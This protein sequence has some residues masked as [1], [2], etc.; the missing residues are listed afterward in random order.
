MKIITIK[1]VA[2]E[3]GVSIT[4]VSHSLSGGGVISKETR[5]HV[6]K[7]A[8]EMQYVPNLNGKNLKAKS[9]KT[10]G[11]FVNS[12][13][14][15]YYGELADVMF[16]E[17][18]K[19]GYNLNIFLTD[20]NIKIMTDIIGG[21]V[22]GAVILNEWVNEE[23]VQILRSA[24][25]PTVFIDREIKDRYISSIVFDSY[26]EGKMAAEYLLSLGHKKIAYIK[27]LPN[28]YDNIERWNGF[29]TA[30]E[31]AGVE[32]SEEYIWDGL[33][34]RNKAYESVS[35]FLDKNEHVVP[36]AIFAANDLSAFGCIEALQ[37]R[38]YKVPEDV[39]V[40]GCDDVELCNYF[41]PK[42]TTI[43]TSFRKQGILSIQ[44]ILDLLQK[45]ESVGNIEK[46]SGKIIARDSC[47][48]NEETYAKHP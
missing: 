12:L 21:R 20:Q 45:K 19:S 16:D 36:E 31:S 35:E 14:G 48:S 5:E 1:D 26:G 38:G 22:D 11:L 10:I 47:K 30:L 29:R 27:G 39:S 9:S 17:C 46:I 41:T 37:E 2:K 13:K 15:T 34:E 6:K 33:F 4:T 18:K 8:S 23:N 42:L 32:L 40:M 28:N 25:I 43:H 7:V 44:K 24:E 3:A